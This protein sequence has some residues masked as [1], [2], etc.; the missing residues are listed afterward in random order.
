[1]VISTKNMTPIEIALQIDEQGRTT[2]K[3][4]YEFLEL[5]KSNYAKWCRVNILEN[6]FTEE[7]IDYE[8]FVFE[9]ENDTNS[10]N[11]KN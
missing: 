5:D 11:F 8:V 6:S 3:K 10:G 4:L 2:A 1:M 7:N 9:Y